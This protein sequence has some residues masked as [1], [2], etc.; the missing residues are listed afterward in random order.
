MEK[1]TLTLKSCFK[2]LTS[3]FDLG[4]MNVCP[5]LQ[6]LISYFDEKKWERK[7]LYPSKTPNGDMCYIKYEK[8]VKKKIEGVRSD[9]VY[10]VELTLEDI[11]SS[12][13]S[14][15]TLKITVNTYDARNKTVPL[16]HAS[17]VKVVEGIEGAFASIMI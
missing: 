17:E 14:T 7:S 16:N 5:V 9:F 2:N 12:Y 6:E 1:K 8:K 10:V 15:C 11:Q 4:Q 3:P 13:S